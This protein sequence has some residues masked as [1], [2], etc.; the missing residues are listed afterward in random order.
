MDKLQQMI[1]ELTSVIANYRYKE[2]DTE[3]ILKYS[4]NR[5]EISIYI[6]A[7]MKAGYTHRIIRIIYE[8]D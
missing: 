5:D 7:S 3:G 2:L 6:P 1:G 8:W 4:A